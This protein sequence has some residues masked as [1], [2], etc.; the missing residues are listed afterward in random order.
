MIIEYDNNFLLR[1]I[2][3]LIEEHGATIPKNKWQLVIS[4]LKITFT[5]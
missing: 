1:R 4:I 3:Y 2:R 5:V